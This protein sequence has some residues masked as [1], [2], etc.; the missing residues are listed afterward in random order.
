MNYTNRNDWINWISYI[1]LLA[2]RIKRVLITRFPLREK[3][4]CRN[5]LHS[6]MTYSINVSVTT[7]LN[8][9]CEEKKL[10]FCNETT[11]VAFALFT[12]NNKLT[13]MIRRKKDHAIDF[14]SSQ[15]ISILSFWLRSNGFRFKVRRNVDF[16]LESI[17][18]KHLLCS[19]IYHKLKNHLFR[20]YTLSVRRCVLIDFD[21]PTRIERRFPTRVENFPLQTSEI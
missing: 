16:C 20:W 18:W 17:K 4:P 8:W 5:A 6:L 3:N 13:A 2:A 9:T 12:Y 1:L 19:T 14:S 11:A 10:L 7:Q 21:F 15:I